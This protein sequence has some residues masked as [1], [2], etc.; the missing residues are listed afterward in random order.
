MRRAAMQNDKKEVSIFSEDLL[1]TLLTLSIIVLF[2]ILDVLLNKGEDVLENFVPW[3]QAFITILVVFVG[4]IYVRNKNGKSRKGGT[5]YYKFKYHT[6]E[7]EEGFRQYCGKFSLKEQ[8]YMMTRIAQWIGK[9]ETNEEKY[10]STVYFL[11]EID[12]EFVKAWHDFNFY[13][14]KKNLNDSELEY[15][16]LTKKYVYLKVYNTYQSSKNIGE[17]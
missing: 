4:G 1:W 11:Q 14:R 6:L 13:E 7:L 10:F 8:L 17:R 5:K 3:L 9:H 16:L 12:D 15:F 2:V